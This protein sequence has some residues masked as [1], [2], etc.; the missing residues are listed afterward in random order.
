MKN[1]YAALAPVALGVLLS[2]CSTT[3][4]EGES[5]LTQTDL[6][7]V[8]VLSSEQELSTRSKDAASEPT[9]DPESRQTVVSETSNQDELNQAKQRIADLESKLQNRESKIALLES[10]IVQNNETISQLHVQLDEKDRQILAISQ[11]TDN[12][13]ESLDELKRTRAQR[14][15]LENSY[16][17]LKIENDEL[18]N[19]LLDL[20]KENAQLS[21]ELA[22][23]RQELDVLSIA[24]PSQE[25]IAQVQKQ[26]NSEVAVAEEVPN[27]PHV[28]TVSKNEFMA[29]ND[30]FRTLDSAHLMLSKDY[31]DLQLQY[32]DLKGERDA[33]AKQNKSDRQ[34]I[35]RLNNEN[36]RLGGALSEARAQHQILW[37]KI[38]VQGD[39]ISSLE[40]ENA[41]LS[42][43][44]VKVVN[45]SSPVVQTADGQRAETQVAKSEKSDVDGTEGESVAQANVDGTRV[46]NTDIINNGTVAKAPTDDARNVSDSAALNAK[47]V[48][49]ESELTAQNRIIS[50]YQNQ[51]FAL[52]NT[53]QQEGGAYESLE[54]KWR[55]LEKQIKTA[56]QENR[57]LTAE[58]RAL[59]RMLV[60]NDEKQKQL[61]NV[62][63]DLRSDKQKLRDDLEALEV[64]AEQNSQEKLALEAQVNNLI[65]FEG[66]VLSLQTQL[67]SQVSDVSWTIPEKAIVNDVF[68][69]LVSADIE[70]PVLGQTYLAELYVDSAIDM[71]SAREAE[72]VVEEGVVKFRWR[73]GG[74]AEIP[75]ATVNLVITQQMNYQDEIIKRPVYK[76][77]NSLQL[78]NNNLF[79]KYGLWGI[80]ILAALGGGFLVGKLGRPKT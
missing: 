64:V 9:R 16:A 33:L 6:N 41:Q 52:E 20:S 15:E 28:E 49:L 55:T 63:A 76:G 48:R 74:L 78:Q 77:E 25:E 30:S 40:D 69:V 58:L 22:S 72:S 70:N 35:Q 23:A 37:D 24:S 36:L 1:R 80:A 46:Q 18:R 50:D 12:S 7:A 11:S 29:L 59:E 3:S 75:K 54:Q 47:I 42:R 67:K 5:Q 21:S 61:S 10:K 39:V 34:N 66:A 8:P 51:V 62:L 38:R 32:A 44:S 19:E 45:V 31:R 71:L 43:S 60:E 4:K 26:E 17:S 65:P 53:L 2:A 73:L 56:E 13:V 27:G 79:E 57:L 14:D 68:E